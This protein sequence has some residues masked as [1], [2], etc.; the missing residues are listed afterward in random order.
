MAH[1]ARSNTALA[2][3]PFGRSYRAA[4]ETPLEL[5]ARLGALPAVARGVDVRLI[6]LVL[7]VASAA[8]I[9]FAPILGISALTLCWIAFVGTRRAVVLELSERM[10]RYPLP[11]G[12]LARWIVG[13]RIF[14]GELA[15]AGLKFGPLDL[16]MTEQH[17]LAESAVKIAEPDAK[18]WWHGPTTLRVDVPWTGDLTDIDRLDRLVLLLNMHREEL[19]LQRIELVPPA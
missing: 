4:S 14:S 11:V 1:P 9:L 17:P 3:T 5:R 19:D 10:R 13:R 7:A 12:H 2:P 18:S 15:E 8:L 16:V 6:V